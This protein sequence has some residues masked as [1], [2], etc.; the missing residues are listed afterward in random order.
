[1]NVQWNKIFTNFYVFC[2]IIATIA[3]ISN[4]FHNFLMDRDTSQILFKMYHRDNN[5]IY[6]SVSL[7]FDW[8]F[9]GDRLLG[10]EHGINATAYHEF[11]SGKIW[12]D[13]YTDL[14]YD[15]VTI[16][17]ESY[18]SS[19]TIENI[20]GQRKQ[21]NYR[22]TEDEKIN[23]LLAL[24]VSSKSSDEKC[25]TI[26]IPYAENE[27]LKTIN[28]KI[29]KK[30]FEET[31]APGYLKAIKGNFYVAFHYPSQF[32]TSSIRSSIVPYNIRSVRSE[33][34]KKG[35]LNK[36]MITIEQMESLRRRDKRNEHC[37]TAWR[38]HDD[39][40]R[41]HLIQDIGCKPHH[42]N[43]KGLEFKNCTNK[44][45]MAKFDN[46]FHEKI[47][48]ANS[49]TKPCLTIEKMFYRYD[50]VRESLYLSLNTWMSIMIEFVDPIYKEIEYVQGM[51]SYV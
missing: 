48:G 51:Q 38:R 25:F 44:K 11:L 19:I 18:L 21:Y 1:M 29:G 4:C 34:G 5:S 8:P 7:C 41:K 14:K 30:L 49:Y 32:L 50:E 42:W 22:N 3:L 17:L 12:D 23:Q 33:S 31:E 13:R 39:A 46:K 24:E 15:N 26:N 28:I 45:K 37:K 36:I 43:H 2:C 27:Y 9:L 10:L 47:A 16:N 40:F 6:P 35:P 20:N